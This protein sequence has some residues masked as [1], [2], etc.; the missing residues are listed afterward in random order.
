MKLG[1]NAPITVNSNMLLFYWDLLP[2]SSDQ[3]PQPDNTGSIEVTVA[4]DLIQCKAP[5]NTPIASN[6]NVHG[7]EVV[8]VAYQPTLNVK[9][10]SSTANFPTTIIGCSNYNPPFSILANGSPI[11]NGTTQVR[12]NGTPVTLTG[13]H[14]ADTISQP[15][16]DGG[17]PLPDLKLDLNK[18]SFIAAVAPGGKCTNG[19]AAFKLEIGSDTNGWFGGTNTITLNQ[20]K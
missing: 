16:C 15:S 13:S 9:D 8:Q 17:Q 4:E 11:I 7:E 18:S 10:N 5:D 1:T 19:P 6:A 14:V 3:F 20:C 12:I 2:P